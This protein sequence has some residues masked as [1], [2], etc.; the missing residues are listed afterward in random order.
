MIDE[1]KLLARAVYIL[2]ANGK[3][4]YAEIVPEVA[5]EPNYAPALEALKKLV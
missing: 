4:V 2:D 3:I 1:L 5:Q